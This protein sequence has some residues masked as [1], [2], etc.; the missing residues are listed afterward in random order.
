MIVSKVDDQGFYIEPV[1]LDTI[2][3]LTEKV[4]ET[5]TDPITGEDT[6]VM[7]EKPI[8]KPIETIETDPESG[9]EIPT[10]RYETIPDPHYVTKPCP[11]GFFWPR[12]EFDEEFWYEG[13]HAPEPV[14]QPPSD[15]ERLSACEDAIA[16]IM[17]VNTNV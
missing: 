7:V 15:S 9:E 1:I 16:F 17:G 13:G 10:T 12:W 8:M 11:P 5:I 3:F 6:E 4:P 14:P 2:P